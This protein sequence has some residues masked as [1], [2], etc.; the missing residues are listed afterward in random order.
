MKELSIGPIAPTP[1]E[2]LPTLLQWL[3]TL[4]DKKMAKCYM[5]TKIWKPNQYA[6]YTFETEKFK[7]RVDA[8]NP[9]YGQLL[10]FVEQC[11]ETEVALAIS[12]DEGR[13]G[14]FK[15]VE[16]EENV[17]WQDLGETGYLLKVLPKRDTTK[18]VGK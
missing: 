8:K 12:V 2:Q 1:R 4:G 17:S 18:P 9:M 6:N 15:F 10:T 11:R 16:M 5:V 7:A 14:L 3:K 13:N